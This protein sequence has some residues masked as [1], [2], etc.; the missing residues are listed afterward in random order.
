M[1][2]PEFLRESMAESLQQDQK[3]AD[4][5]TLLSL[6][7]F[8]RE[9]MPDYV[10]AAKPQNIARFKKK[11]R[12]RSMSAPS[13]F[14]LRP[15]SSR[16]SGT[17]TPTKKPRS[18]PGSSIDV[19]VE[20]SSP[21]DVH[22]VAEHHENLN[23]VLVFLTVPDLIPGADVKAEVVP[24]LINNAEGDRFTITCGSSTSAELELPVPTITRKIDVKVQSGHFELKL[25]TPSAHGSIVPIS[26]SLPLLDA[27]Q[28]SASNPT[29]FICASCSLPLVQSSKIR[30]YMDLPSEHWE[31]LVDAW[32]CHTDQS[33]HEQVAKRGRGF[34]PGTGQALIGGS[35]ILFE[36]SSVVK[37]N[38]YPAEQPKRGED[39]R[40]VRCIC[41]A[42]VGRCQNH[43]T[44]TCV[45]ATV[46]RLVKYAIRPVSPTVEPSR[47]PLSAFIVEDMMEFVHAH[48]TYRFVISDEED[49]RPRLLIWLFKPSIRLA[50]STPKQYVLPKNGSIHSAKVLF[51][52]LGPSTASTDMKDIL[53][54]YP[55]FPQA[56]YLFYPIDICRRLANLLKESNTSYPE[57]MRT[58]TGLDV[59]WLRRACQVAA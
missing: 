6:P 14:W 23:H 3:S 42:V 49:E 41:G 28:L 40:L 34:W 22:Y 8:V 52:I 53:N 19:D 45:S 37:N 56:E 9:P 15:S 20:K 18:R 10:T 38:L 5:E 39:W 51:K 43:E 35:Y 31:E 4:D 7:E 58:M 44:E 29:S 48:A 11:S 36:E 12:N 54:K 32:M 33:L 55:G 46:Y 59:G 27:S 57:S 1:T 13:L 21:L 25:S 17:C 16:S 26:E 2:L 47:V 30:S 24:S 50:Y